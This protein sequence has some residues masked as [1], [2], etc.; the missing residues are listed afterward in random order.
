[1]KTKTLITQ[2]ELEL[3][4]PN[5]IQRDIFVKLMEQ[6]IQIISDETL[7]YHVVRGVY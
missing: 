4:F 2:A 1:M 3:L 5:Q 7:L 6:L